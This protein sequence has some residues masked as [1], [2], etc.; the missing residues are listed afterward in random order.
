MSKSSDKIVLGVSA[1][2]VGCKVRFDGQHK[3]KPYISST[4]AEQFELLPVC[5]EV[6][7][8]LSVPRPALRLEKRDGKT[9]LAYSS[10]PDLAT[11]GLTENMQRYA[12]RI[13]RE[14]GRKLSGFILKKGSPSCG[15]FKVKVYDRNKVPAHDGQGIFAQKLMALL[16]ALPVEEEGRLNDPNLRRNF[17]DKVMIYAEFRRLISSE[18]FTLKQLIEFHARHKLALMSRSPAVYRDLGKFIAG[19]RK[20]NFRQNLDQYLLRLMQ[21]MSEFPS[22]GKHAN[23]LYHVAGYL[24]KHLTQHD[25]QELCALINDYRSGLIPI[26]VPMSLLRH[27]FRLNENAYIADQSYLERK[28]VYYATY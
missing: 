16:P 20:A 5:P 4:L 22:K 24:K 15:A 12:E 1:C 23:A 26:E 10:Q 25:K 18:Q 14:Q 9:L 27:Y 11:D 13:V 3:N 17:I 8:G 19:L 28:E 7:A 6:A 21:G 2:L